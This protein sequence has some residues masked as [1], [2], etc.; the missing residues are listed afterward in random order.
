[1]RAQL[2]AGMLVVI[3]ESED[4]RAALDVWRRDHTDHVFH[5]PD[6]HGG[7]LHDLGTKSS[8]CREPINVVFN[9]GAEQWRLISNLASSLFMLRGRWYESVEGFWQGLKFPEASKR[10]EIAQLWGPEAVKAGSGASAKASFEFD[11]EKHEF[12]SPGHHSL[13]REA[14]WAKFT[15]HAEA[16]KQLLSTGERPITHRTRRDS[17][18]IPGALMADIWMRVRARLRRQ[19]E[20][21]LDDSGE[22]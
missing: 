20:N 22:A 3:P 12:G 8:A 9:T 18:T 16:R 15:Q 19:D 10:A 7:A 17:I 4:E 6:G 11:G 14:S 21:A 13:M 2:K 5:L 1:V